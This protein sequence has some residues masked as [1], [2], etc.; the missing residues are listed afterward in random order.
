MIKERDKVKKICT[1]FSDVLFAHDIDDLSFTFEIENGQT[2]IDIRAELR[3]RTMDFEDLRTKLNAGRMPEYENYYDELLGS[4]Q[5][6]GIAYIGFMVDSA[7]VHVQDGIL[8]VKL[9]RS[10]S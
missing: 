6:D 5:D 7:D 10:H 1:E 3:G 4:G 2:E 8:T 9:K